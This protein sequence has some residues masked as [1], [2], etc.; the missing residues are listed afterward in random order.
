MKPA[1][2]PVQQIQAL[3]ERLS[4]FTPWLAARFLGPTSIQARAAADFRD[5]RFGGKM[6]CR[7]GSPQ[8]MPGRCSDLGQFRV[9]P[10]Q[11]VQACREDA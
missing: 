1:A 11:Q 5:F 6:A 9:R 8:V 10:D 7:I 3:R 2:E 4:R